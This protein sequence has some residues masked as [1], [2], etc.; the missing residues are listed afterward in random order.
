MVSVPKV[1]EGWKQKFDHDLS[2]F[3]NGSHCVALVGSQDGS[4]WDVAYTGPI[5]DASRWLSKDLSSRTPCWL[6]LASGTPRKA[7]RTVIVLQGPKWMVYDR[8]GQVL[9]TQ[10]ASGQK[11]ATLPAGSSAAA[12]DADYEALKWYDQQQVGRDEL[13]EEVRA[14]AGESEYDFGKSLRVTWLS[15][16]SLDPELM[17]LRKTQPQGY[18]LAQEGLLERWVQLPPPMPPRWVPGV[19][20]IHPGAHPSDHPSAHPSFHLKTLVLSQR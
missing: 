3:E 8:Y 1:G 4:V 17:P 9:A 6:V 10:L 19:R 2:G 7:T 18:R 15:S 11:A 20:C 13:A 12:E 5:A 14:D 16:Q